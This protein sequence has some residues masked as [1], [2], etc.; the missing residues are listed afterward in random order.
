MESSLNKVAQRRAQ[1][2]S[3][4]EANPA[5]I[6]WPGRCIATLERELQSMRGHCLQLEFDLLTAESSG[7]HWLAQAQ[8]AE[9]AAVRHPAYSFA[10]TYARD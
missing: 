2:S 7:A 8:A 5:L 10:S 4:D 9:A 3:V 1:R 6:D